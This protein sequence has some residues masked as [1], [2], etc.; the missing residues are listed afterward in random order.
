MSYRS[1]AVAPILILAA[2]AL[3]GE[4]VRFVETPAWVEPLYDGGIAESRDNVPLYDR[5]IRF[6]DGVVTRYTDIAY[7]LDTTQ[8][9]Q[10]MGTIQ[11]SWLPDKGDLAVHRL[12]ILRDGAVIDLLAQ[13][14]RPEILRRE[15]ELERRSVNGALTAAFAVPG[16]ELGDVL[17][18]TS[19]TSLRDQAL[20][21]AMQAAEPIL[22]E[23]T[24]IGTGRLRLSW[25]DTVPM[26]WK[27]LGDVK[28]PESWSEG[29]FAV[30]DFNLPV[31]EP[32]AMPEDAPGR[33]TIAP[34]IQIGSFADWAEVSQ[35]MSGFYATENLLEPGDAIS[36]EVARIEA[37]TSDPVERA[38]MAL[39]MVQ[40]EVTYLLNGMDG[41][42]YLPQSPHDTW[43]NRYGDCK[44]KSLLLLTML[45]AM[46]I[47]AEA[48]LVDSDNGDAVAISQPIPG[49]FDHMIVRATIAGEDYWL[50]GTSAGTRVATIDEVPDFGWALPL[51]PEGA[52]LIEVEQRWPES[53]DRTMRV[54]YDMS[55]G[56]DMPVLYS[57]EIELRGVMG[58]R[59][60]A[61]AAEQE[62]F[63]VVGVA[64]NYLEDLIGGLVYDAT[65]SY[66]DDAGTVL[67]AAEGMT[68][69]QFGF[70]RG[71][72][73][74]RL[75][76]ATV[77][78]DFK[79]NRA[80]SAWRDIPYRVRGPLAIK[81]QW[82]YRLPPGAGGPQLTGIAD[83]DETAAGVRFKRAIRL[84]GE[85]LA[86][87]DSASYIPAE[88][89]AS[90]LGEQ[91]RAMRRIASGDPMLRI[92]DPHRYW[93][94]DDKT[95]AKQLEPHI[96]GATRLIELKGDLAAFHN[97]RATLRVLARDFEGAISDFDRAIE[98]ETDPETL[99][100]R[101]D[102]YDAVGDH[103]AA[104]A[105]AQMAF[106]LQGDLQYATAYGFRLA[107]AG[108]AEEALELID[109]LGLSG[110][111]GV[112]A[113]VVWSEI[114][115]HADRTAEAWDRLQIWL[116]E[117]PDEAVLLNSQCWT[118][119]IWDFQVELAEEV[120][121]RAVAVSG[122]SAGVLDSRAL[123]FYRMNRK[124][125][126]MADL[127]AALAKEPGQASSLY[128]RGLIR[129]EGGDRRGRDD[130][131]HA[132][133]INPEIARRFE[134]YGLAPD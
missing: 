104:L 27:T 44:A 70:E 34:Q 107:R 114:S 1:L 7:R 5:Q 73:I 116:D 129:L 122:N 111:Q 90:D 100:L 76:G 125:E 37:A 14:L 124:E 8:A 112:D 20:A 105:D 18:V 101:A 52:G 31:P 55:A 110:D 119:G 53:A 9:L 102:A 126:A 62:Q 35:S 4:D 108:R 57:A 88:I 21:G 28:Q 86:I 79:P 11:L 87:A 98:L 117:R 123:A 41:G 29:G 91:R 51:R 26:Q 113:E 12:E 85:T 23:P 22:A 84:S 36:R 120:C 75:P 58:A 132:Q 74:H 33:F 128:L 54:T 131:L 6:E 83:L 106:E 15:R 32:K 130:L 47:E 92:A 30:L 42:N 72:A 46:G 64:T 121:N 78:W 103:D 81:Q 77:N 94:L 56:V 127:D 17:R 97:F 24:K 82:D 80:R 59:L 10:Q 65:I 133:R 16:L 89:P 60:R 93:E 43:A 66:D 61:Q 71:T 45:R 40:D 19:S 134:G 115:G 50:D 95:V 48:V 69:D 96:A 68:F 63:A 67:L 109:Q 13:G 118:A 2:P 38:A 25:P 99:V 39:R 3:A 49:A